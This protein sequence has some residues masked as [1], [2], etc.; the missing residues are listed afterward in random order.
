MLVHSLIGSC[1]PCCGASIVGL[2][3]ALDVA[4]SNMSLDLSARGSSL[5]RHECIFDWRVGAQVSF[6]SQ[7]LS[8]PC[9]SG[10]AQPFSSSRS[11]LKDK[12]FNSWKLW[13]F[14]LRFHTVVL[15]FENY[16][17]RTSNWMQLVISV[18]NIVLWLVCCCLRS[19][20]LI[21]ILAKHSV[22]PWL[23]GSMDGYRM[24]VLVPLV[25]ST[26]TP[27]RFKIDRVSYLILY[28]INGYKW[29]K[30]EGRYM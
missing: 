28:L 18:Q 24:L 11:S 2:M 12:L 9:W 7:W 17:S 27:R 29:P 13:S 21:F 23:T 22:T 20:S 16:S 30:C 10:L 6:S 3:T 26:F 14:Q 19:A 1:G 15:T 8:T 4:A 5:R 25:V